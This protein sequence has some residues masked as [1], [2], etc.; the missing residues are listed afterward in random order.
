MAAT[1]S[2]WILDSPTEW[3]RKEEEFP[4]FFLTGREK[5]NDE[6]EKEFIIILGE[7]GKEKSPRLASVVVRLSFFPPFLDVNT[8]E[9]GGRGKKQVCVSRECGI[10][11]Q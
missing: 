3:T 7:G 9:G 11:I 4:R 10:E 6:G 8:K 2:V 5:R 1:T